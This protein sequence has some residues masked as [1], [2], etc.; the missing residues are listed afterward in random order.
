MTSDRGPLTTLVLNTGDGVPAARVPLSLHRL[1]SELKLWNLLNVG[2]TDE[3]GRCGGLISRDAF[4][5][6]MYKMRFETAP[7]WSSLERRSCFPYAEVVFTVTDATETVHLPLLMSRFSYSTHVESCD[8]PLTDRRVP[9]KI[10]TAEMKP[11][12]RW[13][14]AD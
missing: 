10:R 9:P 5:P 4:V 3:D 12:I 7:Y 1:D 11:D 8:L 13:H 14:V 2:T 6:G